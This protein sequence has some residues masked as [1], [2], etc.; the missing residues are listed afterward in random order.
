MGN[1]SGVKRITEGFDEAAEV[2]ILGVLEDEVE[3]VLVLESAHKIHYIWMFD[4]G[5]DLL[6]SHYSFYFMVLML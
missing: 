3:G 2:A 5:Q 4:R 6:F 1:F